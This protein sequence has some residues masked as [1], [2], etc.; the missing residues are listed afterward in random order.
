MYCVWVVVG[1]SCG[2]R[3]LPVD[4]QVCGNTLPAQDLTRHVR[5]GVARSAVCCV[6]TT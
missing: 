5:V 1:F 6:N 2:W 4:G 3:L